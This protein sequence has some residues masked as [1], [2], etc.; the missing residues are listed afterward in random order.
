M[1]GFA[2]PFAWNYYNF[3]LVFFLGRIAHLSWEVVQRIGYLLPFLILGV[4]C[5]MYCYKKI[6]PHHS[7]SLLAAGLYLLNS[8][9]LM[10]IGGGQIAGIGFAYAFLPLILLSFIK[11]I[12][13]ITKNE[14]QPVQMFKVSLQ[15]SLLFSLEI[16]FD[17]RFAYML[18]IAAAIYLLLTLSYI[19]PIK[20]LSRLLAALLFVFI[21]PVVISAFLHAFWLLPT[22]VSHQS[23]TA[24]LSSVYT[25][26]NAVQYFSFAKLEDT[27]SLLHPNWPENVF[28]LTHFMQ[29]EFLLLPFLAFSSLFFISKKPQRNTQNVTDT[30]DG[31]TSWWQEKIIFYFCLLGLIGAFLAK[32]ANDPFGG[33]Y[34]WMFSHVPGFIMFRDPTKWYTL[35]AVSYSILIPFS[36]RSMYDWLSARRKFSIFNFQFSIRPKLFNLQN[37]FLLL[38]LGYLLFLIRPALLGKL[39]GTFQTHHLPKEYARLASYLETQSTFSRTLWV[40]AIQRYGFYSSQHPE[41]SAYDFFHVTAISE[42]FGHLDNKATLPLLQESAVKYIIVPYDPEG[43]IFLTDRKYDQKK[44]ESTVIQLQKMPWL[45]QIKGFGKIAVFEMNGAKDH[46]W[47]TDPAMHIAYQFKNPSEYFLSVKNA[48]AGDRIIF[49]EAFD[50]HWI[51]EINSSQNIIES[52]NYHKSFTSF[53]LPASGKYTLHVTYE[54]Q[55]LVTMGLILSGWSLFMIVVIGSWIIIV[56]RKK[57]I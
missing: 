15:T 50:S 35:V 19:F 29:P 17:L 36:I 37:I 13:T 40:P 34:L 33:L 10:V 5:P 20:N 26:Q 2:A 49:S 38:V 12:D 1:G 31:Y 16:F 28:G 41:V 45:K 23:P 47:S 9:S 32:G 43:E 57:D 51:A 8:Y 55:K 30:I 24:A 27:I 14:V 39:T 11:L 7:F 54:P 4:F 25:T 56:D 6:F 52:R 18:I 3:A 44:Y 22:L 53:L 21:I 46:F 48:K 42:V